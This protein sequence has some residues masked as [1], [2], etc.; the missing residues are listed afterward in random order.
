MDLSKPPFNDFS[1]FAGTF[2]KIKTK[3]QQIRP[4]ILNPAQMVI[5]HRIKTQ[6]IDRGLPVRVAILKGRQMGISTFCQAFLFWGALKPNSNVMTVAHD[7]ESTQRVFEMARFF[8]ENLPPEIKPMQ[9]YSQRKELV[10]E[11]PDHKSRSKNPGLRSRLEIRTAGNIG[12]GKG[13][14]INHLHVSEISVY[15]NP[16][17]IASNLMPAVPY[18]PGTSIFVESTAHLLGAWF[19]EFCEK[20]KAQEEG[21]LYIFLPWFLDPDY[22]L[23]GKVAEMWLADP[24][25]EYEKE[26]VA[27]YNLRPGH[28]AFRR[29]KIDELGSEQLFNQEYPSSDREAW[30]SVGAPLIEPALL[31]VL[32]E[33]AQ[34]GVCGEMLDGKF[35]PTPDG[36]M[37]M[38]EPPV[39][40]MEYTVGVDS[41]QGTQSADPAAIQVITAEG[42]RQRQVA[43]WAGKEDPI[44]LANIVEAIGHFYNEAMVAIEINGVGIATQAALLQRYYNLY[45]W[46]YLDKTANFT[47]RV[48]WWTTPSSKPP[49]IANFRH[50][51]TTG[52]LVI[53]DMATLEELRT[54]VHDGRGAAT[55]AAGAHD[56]LVMALAIASMCATLSE[57][58]PGQAYP[59]PEREV[60]G[61]L[62]GKDPRIYDLLPGLPGE[63]RRTWKTS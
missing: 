52:S 56:D 34:P 45:R 12:S 32:E 28:I 49:L 4:L 59:Q 55:A 25:D 14:T 17:L 57:G 33:H 9:R 41:S 5:W 2:L 15:R 19:K 16:E 24:L 30:I 38:W 1:V 61:S 54:F 11:N 37:V 10:F 53:R 60:A 50:R 39:P 44:V 43:R 31:R 62:R 27:R 48:G 21:Y 3:D 35:V 47:E 58:A 8:Y 23:R 18:E 36:R 22:E 29:M 20:A 40:G 13:L 46:R 63:E 7:M 26:L 6:Q 42:G 51:V